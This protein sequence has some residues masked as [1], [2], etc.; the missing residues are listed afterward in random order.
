MRRK[1]RTTKKI[2]KSSG[3]YLVETL[4]ALL[5]GA[6]LAFVLLQTLTQTMRVTSS[7][8]NQ[9]AATLIAQTVLDSIKAVNFSQLQVGTYPLLVNSTNAGEVAP[10]GHPLPVGLNI[11]SLIWTSKSTGNKFPGSVVLDIENATDPNS[12]NAVVTVTWGDSQNQ[13][14]KT[15]ETMTTLH[16]RGANFW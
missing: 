13:V 2:R 15:V 7:N 8:G 9:Q 3:I 12:L 11:G 1:Y 4:V 6:L 5:L 16:Q 14:T 10:A